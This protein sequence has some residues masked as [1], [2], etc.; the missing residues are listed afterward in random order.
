[1]VSIDIFGCNSRHD[2]NSITRQARRLEVVSGIQTCSPIVAQWLASVYTTLS[3]AYG[4]LSEDRRDF[5]LALP[6][7]MRFFC[8][9]SGCAEML[10]DFVP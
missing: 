8:G 6:R 7:S 10:D 2:V 4:S 1:M 9:R 3:D 5:G